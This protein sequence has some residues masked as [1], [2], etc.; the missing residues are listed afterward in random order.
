MLPWMARA[1][2]NPTLDYPDQE[3]VGGDSWW[4]DILAF[5][6]TG[7]WFNAARALDRFSP[8]GMQIPPPVMP[9]A[10]DLAQGYKWSARTMDKQVP[11][12]MSSL[13]RDARSFRD[14]VALQRRTYRQGRRAE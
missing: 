12:P 14:A 2:D 1:T 9:I 10:N 13:E 7:G 8:P 6:A 5:L 3:G 11:R 4:D